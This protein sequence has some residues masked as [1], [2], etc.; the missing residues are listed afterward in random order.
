ME[1]KNERV[2]CHMSDTGVCAVHNV[3]VERRENMKELVKHIPKIMSAINRMLG[4]SLLLIFI[5]GG[6]FAYTRDTGANSRERDAKLEAK[7]NTLA[8][9]VAVLS[10]AVSASN[11]RNNAFVSQMQDLK[12]QLETM[13][14]YLKDIVLHY[15]GQPDARYQPKK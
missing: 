3:E 7:V 8:E 10:N 13:N 11:E 2:E 1:Q 4:F 15:H 12:V 14:L 9:Q 5:I 6:A